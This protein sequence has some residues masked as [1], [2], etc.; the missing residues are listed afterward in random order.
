MIMDHAGVGAKPQARSS[1]TIV[2]IISHRGQWL[3]ADERNT[4]EAFVR[5]FVHGFGTETDVRDMIGHL[6]ISHDPP[7]S[8]VQTLDELLDL[9]QRAGRNLP[10]A[11]NVKSSGLASTLARALQKFE[12]SSYFL[13]DMAVPDLIA[14]L[15][16]GLTCFT[17]QSDLEPDPVLY[18]EC[19]GV[20]MDT[21]RTDWITVEKVEASLQ[22]DKIVAIVSPELHGRPHLSFWEN[23]VQWSSVNHPNLL[24]CTDYPEEASSYFSPMSAA[25]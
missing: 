13:F 23:L 21:L 1:Y 15:K 16:Q 25:G 17:R 12:V 18:T 4:R 9:H 11:L 2:R 5:S 19:S 10:L 24:L 6:V 8:H 20:W 22:K 14:C 7:T 3:H